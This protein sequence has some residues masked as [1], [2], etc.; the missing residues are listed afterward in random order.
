VDNNGRYQNVASRIWTP[1][2]VR[3]RNYESNNTSHTV[4]LWLDNILGGYIIEFTVDCTQSYSVV[5]IYL[6]K[7]PQGRFMK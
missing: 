6:F 7:G 4:D 2:L 5:E 1:E 3:K